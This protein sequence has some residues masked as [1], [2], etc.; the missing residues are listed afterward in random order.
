MTDYYDQNNFYNQICQIF[1]FN[2]TSL[3]VFSTLI[4][5]WI[6]LD[7]QLK[8]AHNF[9]IS[10]IYLFDICNT[11]SGSQAGIQT[12]WPFY[13]KTYSWR[14]SLST[15]AII[16]KWYRMSGWSNINLFL[17]LEVWD[18]DASMVMFWWE[19]FSWLADGHPISASSDGTARESSALSSFCYKDINLIIRLT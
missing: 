10:N 19:L 7:A 8:S 9:P 1:T 12:L 16:T 13:R 5:F 2:F 11:I 18:Q 4:M 17:T 14:L 3:D 15:L 6:T